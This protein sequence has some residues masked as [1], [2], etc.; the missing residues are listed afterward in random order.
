MLSKLRLG[1]VVRAMSLGTVDG[2]S[3]FFTGLARACSDGRAAPGS[4][5]SGA[6]LPI[7]EARLV[8][9]GPV[10]ID[11]DAKTRDF[12]RAKGIVSI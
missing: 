11:R 6:G 12:G 9:Y 10:Q 7:P 5:A 4:S 8:G 2:K 1:D 3:T